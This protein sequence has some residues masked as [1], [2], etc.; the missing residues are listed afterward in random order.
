MYT[1]NGIQCSFVNQTADFLR[2][3]FPNLNQVSTILQA[4]VVVITDPQGRVL[5]PFTRWYSEGLE[6]IFS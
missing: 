4:K 6:I 5:A 3:R 2:L 1:V